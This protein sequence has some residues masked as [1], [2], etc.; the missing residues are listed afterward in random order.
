MAAIPQEGVVRVLTPPRTDDPRP[1]GAVVLTPPSG[2]DVAV[3]SPAFAAGPL[4]PAV[5]LDVDIFLLARE[6]KGPMLGLAQGVARAAHTGLPVPAAFD[7][8]V[9]L[10]GLVALGH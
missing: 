5:P 8:V 10:V 9:A 6:A 2:L 7:E 4:A 3:A 1:R